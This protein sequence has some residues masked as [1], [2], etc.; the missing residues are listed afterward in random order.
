[1]PACLSDHNAVVDAEPHIGSV[2]LA[3]PLFAHR[4]DH[5]LEPQVAT[6]AANDKNLFKNKELACFYHKKFALS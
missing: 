5:F 4:S 2:N 1:M 6:N 3:S